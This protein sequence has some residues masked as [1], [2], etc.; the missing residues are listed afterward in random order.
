MLRSSAQSWHC[1]AVM[2]RPLAARIVELETQML[3]LQQLPAQVAALDARVSSVESQILQLR[4]EM[5]AEFSTTRRELTERI[6]GK[7]DGLRTEIIDK[8]DGD[9]GLREEMA[10]IAAGLHQE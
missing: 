2:P 5:K 1:G 9:G 4:A 3:S 6:D 8:I 10:T 7:V